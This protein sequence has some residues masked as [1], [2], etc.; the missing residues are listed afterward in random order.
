MKMQPQAAL[1]EKARIVPAAALAA[2]AR[3]HRGQRVFDL[4][5]A[6]HLMVAGAWTG[7]VAI[8]TVAFM[9]PGLVVPAAIFAIGVAALFVTPGLW[10]AVAG[11][12]LPKQSW[13]E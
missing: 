13:A 5:P 8:L 9:G 3:A 2:G 12:D 7:F 6:I 11:D 4:H 10:A 1:L